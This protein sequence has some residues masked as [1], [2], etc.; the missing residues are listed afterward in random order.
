MDC[1]NV[2][3]LRFTLH[4]CSEGKGA[5]TEQQNFLTHAH[6]LHASCLW[7]DSTACASAEALQAHKEPIFLM[8][9]HGRSLV[10]TESDPR[11]LQRMAR[12]AYL[13]YS[14]RMCFSYA[15]Q[16]SV[17]STPACQ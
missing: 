6:A 1:F 9:Y 7:Q 8:L 5:K 2:F 17:G 12:G 3:L 11:G 14:T 13:E 10:H 15:C 4:A 16:A